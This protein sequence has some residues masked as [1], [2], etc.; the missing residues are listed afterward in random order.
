MT[1]RCFLFIGAVMILLCVAGSVPVAA[2][3]AVVDEAGRTVTVPPCPRRIVSLAPNITETLFALEMEDRIVGVSTFSDYP[4]AARKKPKVGSY[5]NLSLEKI[6]SLDPD[7]V[8]GT[9]AGNKKETVLQLERLGFPVYVINPLT[10]DDIFKTIMHIGQVA[11]RSAAAEKLVATLKERVNAVV[12]A[13]R[14]LERPR[15]FFQI[16]IDPMV[17]VGKNTIH[18]TLIALAGGVNVTGDVSIEYPRLSMEQVVFARPDIIIV[19]SMKRGADFEIVRDTWKKWRD[20]PAV[21]N[22]RIHIINS[23]LTDHSSPRIVDGLEELVRIIHPE[24]AETN[25]KGR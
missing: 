9:V 15:V 3:G 24:Q 23:D 21:R 4:E 22:D 1:K 7:L 16:G 14:G 25:Q 10:F 20:I 17:T 12:S 6:V 13:T 19:S 18:N 2:A 11:G 8:I 5:I